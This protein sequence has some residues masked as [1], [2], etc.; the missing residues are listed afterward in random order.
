MAGGLTKYQHVAQAPLGGSAVFAL[1][2]DGSNQYCGWSSMLD[3]AI[4]PGFFV[5]DFPEQIEVLAIAHCEAVKP[6]SVSA[7]CRVYAR[8]NN[9]VWKS[10]ASVGME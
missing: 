3:S 7:P 2:V 9:I 8:N 5:K 4:D 6:E 10:N 1:A